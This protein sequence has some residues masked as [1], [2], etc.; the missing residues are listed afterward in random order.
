VIVFVLVLLA[1]LGVAAVIAWRHVRP[2][3]VFKLTLREGEGAGL[4]FVIRQKVATIGSEEGQTV[5]VS[6]P[7]VSRRHAVVEM[8]GEDFVIR[9]LSRFGIRVNG[10]GAKEAALHSGD[11]IRLGD[12]IDLIFTRL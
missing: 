3:P 11:L 2:R 8:R 1:V 6:H 12:S 9:D 7:K 5:V 10:E 4:D